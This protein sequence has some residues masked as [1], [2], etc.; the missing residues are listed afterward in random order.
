[1]KKQLGN[2]IF[3]L[4]VFLLLLNDWLLKATFHNAFTGKLSDFVGLLA[5]PFLFAALFPKYKKRIHYLT[6]LGFVYWKSDYS[7]VLIDG[8][9]HLGLPIHRTVDYTDLI[10]L[11]SIYFSYHLLDKDW[12]IKLHPRAINMLI[13]ISTVAFIATSVPPH[14]LKHYVDINKEYQ[15]N[16]SKSR[17]ISYL[18]TVQMEGL[19]KINKH[20]G[21]LVFDAETNVFHYR[22]STD[23]VGLILDEAQ[24][25]DTD[26]VRFKTSYV[27]IQLMGDRKHSTL[28]L[29][30]I[31]QFKPFH[32]PK[33][34]REFAIKQFEKHVIKKT[35]KLLKKGTGYLYE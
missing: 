1:M 21:A 27:E 4:S 19:N 7:Q 23:T 18:N 14:E 25:N 16:C 33:G 34:Y 11:I 29:L 6:L 30:S 12:H 28:K 8:L 32:K 35:R 31:Y 9:N 10:A 24:V 20:S 15:F 17:L 3:I 5:F 22:G 26:T 13:G 2:P